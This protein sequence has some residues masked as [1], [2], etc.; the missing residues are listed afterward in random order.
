MPPCFR[1]VL[2]FLNGSFQ[3]QYKLKTTHV[4]E[5]CLSLAEN[6]HIQK[7]SYSAD[8]QDQNDPF[9]NPSTGRKQGGIEP[10]NIRVE[11]L[12]LERCSL[13]VLH[14]PLAVV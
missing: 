8:I 12:H 14:G 6:A 2:G 5:Q 13:P 7:R 3:S 11:F 9:K 4:S 1:P 10:E